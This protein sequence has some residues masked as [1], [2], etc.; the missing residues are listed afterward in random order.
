MGALE[1]SRF[2]CGHDGNLMVHWNHQGL[3]IDVNAKII[4]VWA[5]LQKRKSRNCG[6]VMMNAAI[7]RC[8][9]EY[10]NLWAQENVKTIKF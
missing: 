10:G 2:G 3:G 1:S 8:I 7:F 5:H 4:K 6:D 9:G